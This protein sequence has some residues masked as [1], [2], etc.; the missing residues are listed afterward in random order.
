MALT[1]AQGAVM[2]LALTGLMNINEHGVNMTPRH[3]C[4]VNITL[5]QLSVQIGET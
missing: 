5:Q 1:L 2:N 3:Q 4:G